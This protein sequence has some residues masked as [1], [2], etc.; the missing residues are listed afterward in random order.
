MTNTN[1]AFIDNYFERRLS[2][3][4]TTDFEQKILADQDFANE[5]VF[6]CGT[7]ELVKEKVNQEKIE[8]FRR[9]YKEKAPV[10]S[11]RKWWP[12]AAA[13]AAVAGIVFLAVVNLKSSSIQELADR[14]IA[15]RISLV[16]VEMSSGN[17]SLQ[18]ARQW[19][20]EGRLAETGRLLERLLQADPQNDGA[21]LLAGFVSLRLNDYDN[22]IVHFTALERMPLYANPGKFYHALTLIKRDLDEDR[23]QA[24]I[25]FQQVVNENLEGKEYAADWLK[26]L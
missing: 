17:D 16:S 26:R 25:L 4:E 23:A 12:Y 21:V 19:Y 6:Y 14:Y 7:L 22:A 15:E 11:L 8:R 18:V 3:Q 5:V 9:I 20:N 1:L 13:A 10:R 2:A 24:K